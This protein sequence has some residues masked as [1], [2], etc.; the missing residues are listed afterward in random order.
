MQPIKN[1]ILHPSRFFLGMVKKLNPYLSEETYL[2]LYYFFQLNEVLHLY[3]PK[4]FTEKIQWLK[5][6]DRNPEHIKMVD[7]IGVKDFIAKIISQDI[8]IP[9]LGTYS[10]FDDINF[11]SLPNSFVLKTNHSGGNQGVVICKDKWSFDIGLAKSKLESS[12]KTDAYPLLKE[13]P[14]KGVERRIFAEK[15]MEDSTGNLMDYKF[16]CFNGKVKFTH[17][18]P[19]RYLGAKKMHFDYYDTEWRKMPFAIE[20]PNSDIF[21]PKPQSYELMVKY[22]ELL[23]A[24]AKTPLVRIDFYEVEGKPYFGEITFFPYSGLEKFYQEEWNV[25]LGSWIDLSLL[26][27]I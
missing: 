12:M 20:C 3:N 16:M 1:Y 25:R 5:L 7:K 24:E 27:K 17:I 26:K 9:I 4:K 21:T 10:N 23:A 2:R 14:Y 6:H 15:Y 13:W 22:A 18:C 11:D 8:V 19:D